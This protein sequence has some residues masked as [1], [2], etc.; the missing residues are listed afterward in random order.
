MAGMEDMKKG[1]R[2]VRLMDR[3]TVNGYSKQAPKGMLGLTV[4]E[5]SKVLEQAVRMVK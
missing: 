2:L 5:A 4:A 3:K 1:S